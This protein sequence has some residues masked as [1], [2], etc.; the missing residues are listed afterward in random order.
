MLTRQ[1]G[2]LTRS[3]GEVHPCQCRRCRTRDGTEEV[4]Q[5][6]AAE[7]GGAGARGDEDAERL[8]G[9]RRL[10]GP[11][12]C[13]GVGDH[14]D[15]AGGADE[16]LEGGLGGRRDLEEVRQDADDAVEPAGSDAP[17]RLG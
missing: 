2:G 11:L 13:G 14:Q 16:R 1:P 12:G 15:A 17:G 3:P 6:A 10:E 8:S 4:G 5:G 9:S 7:H